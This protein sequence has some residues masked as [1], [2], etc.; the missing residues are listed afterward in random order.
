VRITTVCSFPCPRSASL[1]GPSP[2]WELLGIEHALGP[3]R[4]DRRIL[5]P[6]VLTDASVRRFVDLLAHKDQRCNTNADAVALV[7]RLSGG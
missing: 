5:D 6:L 7:R 2:G 4:H 3:G 1:R